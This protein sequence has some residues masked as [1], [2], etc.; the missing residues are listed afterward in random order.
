VDAG[1]LLT[2]DDRTPRALPASGRTLLAWAPVVSWAAL[3][4]LLSAQPNLRFLPDPGLD[5]VVRKLGHVGVFGIL[6]LLLWHALAQ[7]TAWRRPWAW[8]FVLTVLYAASDEFHQEFVAGR[9]PSVAD[10]VIDATGALIAL[11]AVGFIQ[12]RRS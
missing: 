5:F 7:K 12:S 10:V 4:F 8:A 6:A 1:T 2:M 11:I 9:H 3:I